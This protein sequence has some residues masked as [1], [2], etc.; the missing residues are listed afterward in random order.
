MQNPVLKFLLILFLAVCLQ[1]SQSLGRSNSADLAHADSLFQQKQYT[2][3]FEVYQTIFNNH[4]YTPAMLLK[5]AY[6][7]E[8]LNQIA[9]SIYYLNVYYMVAQDEAVLSKMNELAD[10][11]RLEGYAKSEMEPFWALY[12]NYHTEITVTI[13][14][15]LAFLLL[16]VIIQRFRHH[17]KPFVALSFLILFSSLL[18]AHM[19]F[20]QSHAMGIISKNNTYLMDGPSAGSSVVSIVRDGH[21]VKIKGRKDVW[22]KVQWGEKDVYVKDTHLLPVTL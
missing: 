9:K 6:V 22:I 10:K 7:Q 20:K 12:K 3:S 8:G 18:I 14:A 16:L 2:Q 13:S 21:R 1:V 19:N 5:M 4:Q 15:V 17:Q 11:Y